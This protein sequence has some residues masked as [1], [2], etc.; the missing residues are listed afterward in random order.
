[1]SLCLGKKPAV[2]PGALRDLTY[3]AAGPLPKPPAS[4]AVPVVPNPGTAGGGGLWGMDDNDTLGDCGV[5]GL[6]HGFMA[7]AALL[8]AK[9]FTPATAAQ[10]GTYYMTYDHGQDEGVVLSAYLAYV[11]KNKFYGSTIEGYAPVAEHDVPTLQ[12]CIATYGFAYV[13]I[14]VTDAMMN[15]CQGSVWQPWTQAMLSSPIDGGH[16]IILVGYDDAYLYGITWGGVQKITYGAWHGMSDEAWA[17]ITGTQVSAN[18]DGRG[19]NLA[20]L[21]ADISKLS[22]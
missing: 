6:N 1:M 20:A 22:A 5:A 4:V 13:G 14:N 21:K 9:S 11:E 12:F 2:F 17:V 19:V 3:Y 10:C 7:D 15:A 8:K 18:S 16:C